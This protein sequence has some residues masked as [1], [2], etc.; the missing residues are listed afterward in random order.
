M[1]RSAHATGLGRVSPAEQRSWA[2][3]I[4]ALASVLDRAGLGAVPVL[5]EYQLPLTSKRVDAVIAG[6]HPTTGEPSYVV[7]ELKQWSRASLFESSPELV[8]VP[9]APGPPR[10][11]PVLQVDDYR[12][13]L[14]G[15][16]T[17]L[18]DHPERVHGAA[19]LHNV[20][21][22]RDIDDMWTV[23]SDA[24]PESAT[25]M[26]TGADIGA[27]SDFLTSRLAPTGD[28]V[29][30]DDL[31]NTGFAPSRQLL[32]HAAAE[33]RE[34]E[35]FVLLDR[36]HDAVRLVLHQV[37]AAHQADHKRVIVVS[38]GPGSG[39]SVVALSLLGELARAGRR[40]LHA[41]GSN[42]FTQTLRK[43]AGHR[44]R[45]TQQ[46]FKYFNSFQEEEKHA[47]DVLIAD[48]S[49]RIRE[50]STSRYSPARL[51]ARKRPQLDELIDVA[52]V[53]V[54][55]LD[56]KQVVRPGELGSLYE[57]TRFAEDKGLEVIHIELGE[58][59]R[60][61]GSLAYT[62]WVEDLLQ[63]EDGADA[64]A[65]NTGATDGSLRDDVDYVGVQGVVRRTSD[66]EDPPVLPPDPHISVTVA[67]SPQQMESMLRDK[68][69]Q[70]YS[71]RMSAGFCWRWSKPKKGDHELVDDVQL[72]DWSRPWNNP[73]DR[74]VGDAP[75]RFRW[76][77]AGGG[78]EQIGCIYTAQGFEYDWSGVI[79]G[80]DLVW[81][82]GGFMTVRT[83][84]VDPGLAKKDLTDDEF[85]VLVR[86]VYKV[87]LT[88]GMQ[89]TV[90]YSPDR[91]TRDALKHLVSG[92]NGEVA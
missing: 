15:F 64:P 27:F 22:H 56:E 7:V 48:E 54:F 43:V 90:I 19:Y 13:Y 61:G 69:A 59:F 81:R 28:P 66:G 2:A 5:L 32:S 11:H 67:D 49:H 58:Q 45:E 6:T 74:R 60:C 14:T 92:Q 89:G 4:P 72:G 91:Q 20:S 16:A 65:G 39:K 1:T 46:L 50:T 62:N 86:H 36:Q 38:G 82:D 8:E 35:E 18:A 70:G 29:P 34:R 25:R 3:S 33:I 44:S 12:S 77:T 78:F 10:S 68:M 51:R 84:N 80:P 17:V 79:I 9:G 24:V 37:T 63:L 53:P 57:I 71:A 41:T 73:E 31:M 85:D 21:S 76:A 75:P 52:R 87:L 26:F 88:R 47:L 42:A 30:A 23:H 83:R 55:L 40:V